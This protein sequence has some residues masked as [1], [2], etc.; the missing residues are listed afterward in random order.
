MEASLGLANNWRREVL[1]LAAVNILEPVSQQPAAILV[2]NEEDDRSPESEHLD[3][4]PAEPPKR[5]IF[6]FF[7]HS[8]IRWLQI[9]F[10][11]IK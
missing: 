3:P 1:S 11:R 7:A 9:H 2:V 5:K 6:W 8:W 4:I 10:I